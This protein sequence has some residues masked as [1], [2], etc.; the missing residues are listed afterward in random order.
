MKIDKRDFRANEGAD[1]KAIKD[2]MAKEVEDHK[3][4]MAQLQKQ[5]D[6][7]KSK[8]RHDYSAKK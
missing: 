2:K 1:T 5:L 7:A 8:N 4:K 6:D 3:K